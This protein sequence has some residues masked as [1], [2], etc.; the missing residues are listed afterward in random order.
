MSKR[1]GKDKDIVRHKGGNREMTEA[2][3]NKRESDMHITRFVVADRQGKQRHEGNDR[4]RTRG[5]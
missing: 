2:R 3:Q 4:E 5:N 1:R